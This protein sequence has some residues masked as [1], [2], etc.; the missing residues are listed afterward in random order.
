MNLNSKNKYIKWAITAFT[1]V[2]ASL[3]TY[4]LIFHG[5]N[6]F[7]GLKHAMNICMPIIFGLVL[8]YLL[9]PVLNKI[10]QLLMKLCDK[11][12]IKDGKK[13]KRVLRGIGIF[14]T[15]ILALSCMYCLISMMIKQIIPSVITIINDFDGY[16]K[17]ISTWLNKLLD[18][19]PDLKTYCIGLFERYS[20]EIEEWLNGTLLPKFTEL[21]KTVSLS[22]ISFLKIVWNFIIGLIISIYVMSSKETFAGQS[23]KMVYGL[24]KRDTANEIIHSM[25]FTHKTFIGFISGKIVDSLIIGL[26][27]FIGVTILNIPYPALISVIIGVTNIIPFF[28]PFLGAVPSAILILLVDFTHPMY[29][30]YFVIFIIILQQL[31]GNIIGPKILG[32]STGLS[33][34]W[35]IFSITVF[36]GFFGFTGMIIGVPT[37]A[38]LYAVVR[39]IINKKL[40][41]K[42]MTVNT[43]EYITLG[44]VDENGDFIRYVPHK[45]DG[46]SEKTGFVIRNKKKKK[47]KEIKKTEKNNMENE[48]TK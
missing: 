24:F 20:K 12:K 2:A 38:V 16:I 25:R 40:K 43:E 6:V 29:C 26:L 45:P 39:G 22:I 32:N 7:K 10:E 33:S 31:D 35:V 1:V 27:C 41:E 42:N 9:T 11:M 18:N 34:F 21:L 14:I 4:Y 17:N 8:G 44:N 48:E 28:G 37:F 13:R 47:E 19:N 30:V 23:K 3:I 5:G 46:Y 15:W 36:G